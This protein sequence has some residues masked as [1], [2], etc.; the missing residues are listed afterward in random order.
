[1]N[2]G[3]SRYLKN[4][5]DYPPSFCTSVNFTYVESGEASATTPDDDKDDT[6]NPELT[7]PMIG[8]PCSKGVRFNCVDR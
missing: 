5:D 4:I 2:K 3:S 6:Q 1:M 7:L 8:Y